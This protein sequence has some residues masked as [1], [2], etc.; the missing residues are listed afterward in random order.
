VATLPAFTAI[1]PSVAIAPPWKTRS[2][3]WVKRLYATPQ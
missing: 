2:R 3:N 1:G